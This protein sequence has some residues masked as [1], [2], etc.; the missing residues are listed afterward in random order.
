MASWTRHRCFFPWGRASHITLLKLGV[1]AGSGELNAGA[2]PQKSVRVLPSIAKALGQRLRPGMFLVAVDRIWFQ[3][4]TGEEVESSHK[5][6]LLVTPAKEGSAVWKCAACS[7][8]L[9]VCSPGPRSE[10]QYSETGPRDPESE[11]F[12]A[13]GNHNKASLSL[14]DRWGE[15][16]VPALGF[17]R[18]ERVWRDCLSELLIVQRTCKCSKLRFLNEFLIQGFTLKINMCVLNFKKGIYPQKAKTSFSGFLWFCSI[19]LSPRPECIKAKNK[20]KGKRSIQAVLGEFST[21]C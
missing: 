6:A 13:L 17:K 14:K 5:P 20:G 11:R 7:R 10:W 12:P 8:W 19:L 9:W 3:K 1:F 2:D 15:Q 4:G 16:Q 21:C 18:K